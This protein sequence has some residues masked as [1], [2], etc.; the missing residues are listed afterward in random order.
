M[1]DTIINCSISIKKNEYN[2]YNLTL[3]TLSNND[4]LLINNINSQLKLYNAILNDCLIKT[5]CYN[6]SEYDTLIDKLKVDLSDKYNKS[7]ELLKLEYDNQINIFKNDIINKNLEIDSLKQSYNSCYDN[8]KSSVENHLIEQYKTKEFIFEQRI[9]NE[10]IKFNE[11]HNKINDLVNIR[12]ESIKNSYEIIIN[13]LKNNINI[14]ES[15]NDNLENNSIIVNNLDKKFFNLE[16]LMNSNFSHINKYFNNNDSSHSGELGESFIYDFLSNFLSLNSGSIQRVNGKNNAGDLMLTYNNLKCCIESKNHAS[17]IRQ[18]HI[19][20]FINVD[21]L[22]PEYNSGIFI[23]FKSDFVNSSSIKHFDIQIVHNKPIVFIS[24]LIKKPHE[25]ILAI[26]IIDF[27]LHQQTFDNS[28]IQSYISFLNSHINILNQ[29]LSI[30][31]LLN[32]NIT[33]S[34]NKISSAIKEIEELLN[35]KSKF[36]YKCE[37]CNTGSNTKKEY[38][39][40][41]KNCNI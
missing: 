18:E 36:K 5:K 23:S 25:I 2:F 6:D 9:I 10:E 14:L 13:D 34:N 35:I 41:I 19:N 26:K 39:I 33:E 15:K 32:K 20:R 17:S 27:I 30:N 38:N 40:H 31:N 22:N 24:N 7:I 16:N 37:K 11:L 8:I 28:N 12:S 4:E 29:L 3:N 1:T 21:I